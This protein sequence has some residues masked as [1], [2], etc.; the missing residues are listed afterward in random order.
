MVAQSK[1]K[2][3]ERIDSHCQCLADIQQYTFWDLGKKK[4][5][6]GVQYIIKE[7]SPTFEPTYKYNN[8]WILNTYDLEKTHS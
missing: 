1:N 6:K 8:G 7:C 2:G 4:G 5:R 3:S